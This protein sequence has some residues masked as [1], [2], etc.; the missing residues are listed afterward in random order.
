ME[1]LGCLN[2][3]PFLLKSA[4][5]RERSLAKYASGG[6]LSTILSVK[7]VQKFL[8][9]VSIKVVGEKIW[10]LPIC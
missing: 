8:I 2:R 7:S 5:C 10:L 1:G 6:Q 4:A 9:L 3:Q